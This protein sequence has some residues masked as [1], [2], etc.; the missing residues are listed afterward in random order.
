MSDEYA[1]AMQVEL[2]EW[3][4]LKGAIELLN[5]AIFVTDEIRWEVVDKLREVMESAEPLQ[6]GEW[7]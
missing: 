7:V 2:E 6:K 3:D 1:I 5:D 4:K